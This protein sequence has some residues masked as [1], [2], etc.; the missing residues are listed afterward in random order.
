MIDGSRIPRNQGESLQQGLDRIAP[1][2]V[3]AIVE[4]VST[5][6]AALSY[7]SEIV[8]P[9]E[10]MMHTVDNEDRKSVV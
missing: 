8:E 7:I 1:E 2:H 5:Q 4:L 9:T 3:S 10:V 6:V